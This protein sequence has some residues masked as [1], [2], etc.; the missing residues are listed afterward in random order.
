MSFKKEFK[1]GVLYS[2][3]GKYSSVIIQ[4]VVV[5]ILARLLSPRDFGILGMVMVF[6]AFFNILGNI[7]FGPAIINNQ[8]LTKQD[9]G[10]INNFVILQAILLSVIFF[11]SAS[12]IAE[13]YKLPELV[14][15][16]RI[17]SL[18]IFFN[19]ILT[20]N[21]SLLFKDKKFKLIA[22]IQII[23]S[24]V[25]AIVAVALAYNGASYYAI[26]AQAIVSVVITFILSVVY[27]LNYIKYSLSFGLEPVKKIFGYSFFQ[28]L[29]N[30]I[31]Y[32]S[33]NAD[34]LLVGKYMGVIPL[35]IYDISY[36]LMLFPVQ[37]LTSL[38]ST[39]MQP[40]LADTQ[41][42]KKE[43]YRIYIKFVRL[44]FTISI[45]IS[46]F[47]YFSSKPIIQILYGHKWDA[48]IPIFSIL[49]ISLFVQIV[50]S[51]T[52]SIF[53]VLN[54]T[55]WLFVSGFLSA[56]FMV[57]G[58]ALG[59]YQNSLINLSIYLVLA[60]IINFIQAY[61]ILISICFNESFI[62]FLYSLKVFLITGVIIALSEFFVQ[63][64]LIGN[65]L[66]V[67]GNFV[68]VFSLNFMLLYIMR[69]RVFLMLIDRKK[70]S[71]L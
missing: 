36:R 28:F 37:N 31:N 63:K 6:L 20:V 48:A 66:S 34:N 1:T 19:T 38:F 32:F 51:S 14:L 15:P 13:F 60:F 3:I 59:V 33:R 11:F 29:F 40:L 50:L 55:N 56:I 5:S 30:F 39:V 68:I 24:L 9:Y 53:M 10:V 65:V 69:E 18:S 4:L 23:S 49:S 12:F 70:V 17:M 26:V 41:N 54:K 62:R 22:N 45:P 71:S 47:L 57:G 8:K 43:L 16:T 61:Y 44:L 21:Q 46:I 42:D 58:I 7:G 27:S 35:G 67:I 25:S 2:A 52:G 64:F